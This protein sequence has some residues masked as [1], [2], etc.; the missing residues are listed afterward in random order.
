[1]AK[2]V[3]NSIIQRQGLSIQPDPHAILY[4]MSSKWKE[5]SVPEGYAGWNPPSAE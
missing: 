1:M 3:K 5:W 4:D 2:K